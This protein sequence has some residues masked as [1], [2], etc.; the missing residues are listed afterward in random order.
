[1]KLKRKTCPGSQSENVRAGG[2]RLKVYQH[3]ITDEAAALLTSTGSL[4][5]RCKIKPDIH[6]K[7]KQCLF[8]YRVVAFV[9]HVRCVVCGMEAAQGTVTSRSMYFLQTFLQFAFLT[10]TVDLEYRGVIVNRPG[11]VKTTK[12]E[13][14]SQ[15]GIEERKKRRTRGSFQTQKSELRPQEG[16]ESS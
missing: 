5:C 16:D 13:K 7:D 9:Y 6:N 15:D 14:T 1:M 3:A 2:G 12:E 8:C 10:R 11:S 4:N